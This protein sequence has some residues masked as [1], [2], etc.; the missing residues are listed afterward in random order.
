MQRYLFIYSKGNIVSATEITD[1]DIDEA[2]QEEKI[3]I[4]THTGKMLCGKKWSAVPISEFS[5]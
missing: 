4:D 2:E 1:W 5:K 3:I